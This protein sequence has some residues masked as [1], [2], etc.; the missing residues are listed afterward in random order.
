MDLSYSQN[1]ED[2][3]LSLAF[4]GQATGTY[5]DVGAGHPIA[6]NV[7]FWSMNVAGKALSSSRSLNL[8]RST[9]G[10]VRA[11]LRFVAWSDVI[12]AKWIFM[13]SNACTGSR[14]RWKALRKRQKPSASTIRP[15]ACL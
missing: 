11:T 3:H 13:W 14:R 15:F 2:Y 4:A 8:W 7:S 9:R 5:I 12:A 1:L 6:D 10:C